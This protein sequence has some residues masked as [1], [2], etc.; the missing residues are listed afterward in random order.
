M[1]ISV[2]GTLVVQRKRGR[3]GEFN[4][5]DLSTE[6]GEFEV[7]DALIE[8]FEPGKYTG[9]FVVNWIEP[10]SFSWR[11]KVFVKNRAN[12]DAIY[13]DE[14]DETEGAATPVVPPEPDPADAAAATDGTEPHIAGEDPSGMQSV[15]AL[16]TPTAG[17]RNDGSDDLALL[18]PELFELLATRQ[19]MKLDPTIDRVQFRRQRDRL[20][21]LDYVFNV[22]SQTWSCDSQN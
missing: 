6:I 15:P 17:V 1:S 13:I 19:P 18:G 20:K 22:K 9:E 5:G 4:I 3:K 12:L 7:K 11:G 14:A 8:E 21:A 10:D 16:P 2:R